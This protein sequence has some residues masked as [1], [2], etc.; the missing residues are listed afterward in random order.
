MLLESLVS[1]EGVIVRY[2]IRYTPTALDH[3][4]SLSARDR[5]ML[6]DTVDD[7]LRHQPAVP[8]RHRKRLRSNSLAPWELR[9]GD[10][11]V[12]YDIEAA[13]DDSADP[14]VIVL[15]IG[16]KVGNRLSIGDEEY[17]L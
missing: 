2:A 15:A 7:K 1:F 11:R 13:A 8:T 14:E 3:L 4:R 5:A 17:G 16:L 12:F 6:F 10:Y 9:C